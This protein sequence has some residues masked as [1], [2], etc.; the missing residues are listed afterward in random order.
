M[1]SNFIYSEDYNDEDCAMH[2]KSDNIE[3]M[4]SDEADEV[5][6]TFF[7]SQLKKVIKII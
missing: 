5:T 6:K 3:Y 7:L 1:T 2:S 4:S